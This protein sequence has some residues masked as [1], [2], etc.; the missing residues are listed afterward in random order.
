MKVPEGQQVRTAGAKHRW[1]EEGRRPGR[2]PEAR[3]PRPGS[4]VKPK[5]SFIQHLF[6]EMFSEIY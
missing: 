2:P 6:T 1:L 3:P 4:Q 5:Y